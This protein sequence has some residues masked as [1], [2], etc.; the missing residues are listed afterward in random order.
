MDSAIRRSVVLVGLLLVSAPAAVAS[1][2]P[3]SP[4]LHPVA[5]DVRA[6]KTLLL[7]QAT[8][9]SFF[10]ASRSGASSSNNTGSCGGFDPNLRSLTE[11]AEVYGDVL[12]DRGQGLVFVSEAEVYV[13]SA[14]AAE[15][16][17][18]ETAPGAGRCVASIAKRAAGA[19]AV[20]V[21]KK[22]T[23]VSLTIGATR[24]KAWD[25]QLLVTTNGRQ[26]PVEATLFVYRHGRAV[27]NLL[28]SGLDDQAALLYSRMASAQ[29][30][31]ALIRADLK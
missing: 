29:M 13:S 11:T 18:L 31:R 20:V 3:N 27:S 17:A 1:R 23:P 24:V 30:T 12:T 19:G 28:F 4:V 8:L 9:G 21:K 22:V 14:E 6:A 2:D 5:S 7:R 15:A 16:Q 25:A 10:Q 26:I